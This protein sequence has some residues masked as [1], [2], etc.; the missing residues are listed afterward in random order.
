MSRMWC[1]RTRPHLTALADGELDS[2][3]AGRVR[4]HLARCPACAEV[5]A[6]LA[7]DIA[8]QR[9]ILR[10]AV[11]PGGVAVDSLL[12]RVRGRLDEPEPRRAGWLWP[13]IL[14][15][16]VAAGVLAAVV[17][18]RGGQMASRGAAPGSRV[19]QKPAA[20]APRQAG[21]DEAPA[22]DRA[23]ARAEDPTPARGGGVDLE[24]PR[25]LLAENPDFFRNYLLF[26]RLD[27][28]E[29]F[30]TVQNEAVD[31]SADGPPNG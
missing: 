14:V 17:L 20:T 4:A 25:D 23:L 1:W 19:A 11:E 7:S 6:G 15:S 18:V 16:A 31:P 29:H 13:P 28:I 26:E 3:R 2:R 22:P 21:T 12:R 30:E 27:A 8:R 10:R 24:D 9:E 5:Y